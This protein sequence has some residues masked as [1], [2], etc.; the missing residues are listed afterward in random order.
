MQQIAITA[1]RQAEVIQRPDFTDPLGPDQIRGR[2]IVSLC[3]PGTELNYFYLAKEN[4]PQFPGYACVFEITETGSNI[5]DLKPGDQVLYSGNHCELQQT[6][7]RNVVPLPAGLAP[8]TAVFARLAGVT[9]STLNTTTAH[10]PSRVLVTGL[11]P[12]GNLAA[13]IFSTCGYQ[14]T[15]IDPVEKRRDMA[16]QHGLTDLRP[17]LQNSADLA[18]KMQLQIECSGHEQAT[19]DGIKVVAKGGEVVL[20]GVP[21]QRRT[22]LHAFDFLHAIFHRYVNVRSGWEWEV[23]AHPTDFHGNSIIENYQAALQWLAQGKI[24]VDGM[25]DSYAPANAQK[26]YAALLDQSLPT[27][28]ALF[29]WT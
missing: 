23:P 26:V 6:T 10:A 1:H 27:P 11:G 3:S 9:M 16:K 2:T 7:R 14:V 25:A 19:L 28:T 5:T 20:V 22:E 24:K 8:E 18:N 12:V 17:N 29:S 13:Q 4:F 21:W 15:A